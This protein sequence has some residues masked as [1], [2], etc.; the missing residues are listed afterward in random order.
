MIDIKTT[1]LI[2][3]TTGI[4]VD[5]DNIFEEN[6]VQ[7]MADL[8]GVSPENIRVTNIIREDSTRRRRRSSTET[9]QFE[10]SH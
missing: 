9:V 10:V 8:L 6:V 2:V 1:P 4:V 7:N 3:L 5:P